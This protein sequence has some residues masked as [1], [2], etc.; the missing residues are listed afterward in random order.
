MRLPNDRICRR[1]R[2]SRRNQQLGGTRSLASET[3]LAYWGSNVALRGHL[4]CEMSL[5]RHNVTHG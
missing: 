5:R 1:P 4:R 2:G 3:T